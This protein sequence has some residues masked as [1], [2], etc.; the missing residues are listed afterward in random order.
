MNLN[1]F[2]CFFYFTCGREILFFLKNAKCWHSLSIVDIFIVI[3]P[4]QFIQM[5]NCFFWHA[6]QIVK[7]ID[8]VTREQLVQIMAILGVGNAAP[9]FSMVPTFGPFKPAAL[10][11]TITEED[12]IILNNVQKIVEFLTAGS[13]ISRTSNQVTLKFALRIIH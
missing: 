1:I 11:P 7:G 5:S 3:A 2:S 12:K 4:R 10:L 8:A 9:V 6:N 13:S